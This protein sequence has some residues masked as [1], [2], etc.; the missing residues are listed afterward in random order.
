LA[1]TSGNGYCTSF[2]EVGGTTCPSGFTCEGYEVTS[3][4]F[5]TPNNGL[6]GVCA[7]TCSGTTTCPGMTVCSSL[8]LAGPDCQPQ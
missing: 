8:Y 7:A 5:T 4:G 6:G 2:C 3:V 1:G